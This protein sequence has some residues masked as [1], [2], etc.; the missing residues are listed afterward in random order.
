MLSSIATACRADSTILL[1]FVSW[2]VQRWL[3]SALRLLIRKI[4]R[5]MPAMV[6]AFGWAQRKITAM[7]NIAA[8]KASR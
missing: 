2:N 5:K 1:R 3:T 4:A 8:N 6:K 7:V